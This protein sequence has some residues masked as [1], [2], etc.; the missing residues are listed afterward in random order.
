MQCTED[1][2][3]A[4]MHDLKWH[5]ESKQ[6]TRA[7]D[8]QVSDTHITE[9]NWGN[10]LNAS[11]C[12]KKPLATV[13]FLCSWNKFKKFHSKSHHF[14]VAGSGMGM[15]HELKPAFCFLS[16]VSSGVVWPLAEVIQHT[17]PG[18]SKPFFLEI[19]FLALFWGILLVSFCWLKFAEKTNEHKS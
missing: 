14:R 9:S 4:G 18:E 3:E 17:L 2:A 5:R 16:C 13:R 1:A 10:F 19:F 7:K 6:A 15:L 8:N 12:T 11:A